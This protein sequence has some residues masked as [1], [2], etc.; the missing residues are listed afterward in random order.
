MYTGYSYNY[1]NASIVN[2]TFDFGFSAKI[3]VKKNG[4]NLYEKLFSTENDFVDFIKTNANRSLNPE[5]K[6]PLSILIEEKNCNYNKE[7]MVIINYKVTEVKFVGTN[8]A[9]EYS[10][11][12]IIGVALNSLPE[13]KKPEVS[14]KQTM[15]YYAKINDQKWRWDGG[16]QGDSKYS[17]LAY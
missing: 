15:D 17:K 5:S 4:L 11:R 16:A 10:A 9:K 2:R 8:Y 3:E 1:D 7:D 14:G 6:H 12:G 13:V